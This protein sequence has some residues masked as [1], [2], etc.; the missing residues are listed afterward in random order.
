MKSASTTQPYRSPAW[1]AGL[2]PTLHAPRTSLF[3]NLEVAARRYPDKTA[4]QYFGTAITY[5]ALLDEVERMAGYLQ[6]TCGIQP[7]DRVVLF[8]QNCPQFIVAYYA[9]LR[10]EARWS[11]PIRCGSKPNSNTWWRTAA[12]WLRSAAANCTTAS[13]RCTARHCAT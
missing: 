8:S 2:P 6:H 1:P 9:I 13:H 3:Y 12:P 5:A 11:R 10:A 4:I 7:G